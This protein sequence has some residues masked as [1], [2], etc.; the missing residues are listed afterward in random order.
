MTDS[1]PGGFDRIQVIMVG[2][3]QFVSPAMF[4]FSGPDSNGDPSP[5]AE[6]WHLTFLDSNPAYAEAAGPSDGYQ[7]LAF[8]VQVYGNNQVDRPKFHYQ[9]W[10][11]GSL[12]G[13][14]DVACTGPLDGNWTVLPGTLHMGDVNCDGQVSLLDY[15][16]IKA[17]FGGSG[18]WTSG[19]VNGDGQ[20]SLLDFNVVKTHFGHT[21][22]D[23]GV[24]VVPEP[25]TLLMV[26]LGS[27]AMLRRRR[28]AK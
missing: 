10:R 24:A 25:A 16:V 3:S 17:N 5:Q 2:N 19:D 9:T 13:T 15:N 6:L 8:T 7:F 14:W 1:E 22:G 11:N 20:V 21:A 18:G 27:A 26:G 4:A 12:V 23:T 28:V